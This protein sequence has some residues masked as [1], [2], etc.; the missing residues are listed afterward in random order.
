MPS[1]WKPPPVPLH[2][3][4]FKEEK[5][6]RCWPI[7][8]PWWWIDRKLLSPARKALSLC[9]FK[10]GLLLLLLFF[11]NLQGSGLHG[12]VWDVALQIDSS[13][14]IWQSAV[15]R[16]RPKL[17][18]LVTT[19]F[20]LYKSSFATS[21]SEWP[22]GSSSLSDRSETQ[23]PLIWCAAIFPSFVPKIFDCAAA[24]TIK[25]TTSLFS[26]DG[27]VWFLCSY[28]T[29]FQKFP[30]TGTKPFINKP[31]PGGFVSVE[32]SHDATAF[33]LLST[34]HALWTFIFVLAKHN[35]RYNFGWTPFSVWEIS[36]YINIQI[37]NLYRTW[38]ANKFLNNQK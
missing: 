33:S 12:G 16:A 10:S 14:I 15:P 11:F 6:T 32:T 18:D 2:C 1:C 20:S 7:S 30:K 29:L 34:S 17:S 22:Q 21:Y 25:L 35:L 24:E 13:Q 19:K 27:N 8:F 5:R 38:S 26:C 37:K 31:M 3:A 4:S 36:L 23:N 9:I 28:A